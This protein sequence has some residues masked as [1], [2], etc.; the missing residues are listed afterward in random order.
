MSGRGTITAAILTLDEAVNLAALLPL[1]E[2]ADEI[3]VVDSGSRD[4]TVDVARRHGC[5][6]VERPFDS[7]AGQRNH[8][9][10]L[11]R[12]DWILSIDA[13]ERPVP[14]LAAEIRRHLARP[15]YEAFRLPICSTIFGRRFRRSGT[16]DDRPVRL[17]RKQSARWVGDVHEV[18]RVRGRVGRLQHGLEHRTMPSLE[19]FLAKMHRYTSLEARAR[20]AAG[21]GPKPSDAWIAPLREVFRRLIWKHGILD[22]PEGW[23]FC[24]LSGLSEWVLAREHRR[25][26]D[27]AVV[28]TGREDTSCAARPTHAAWPSRAWARL[29]ENS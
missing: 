20:V 21:R 12:G 27:S 3:V 9:I 2:W 23:A 14:G 25:L 29:A 17:F 16:Q 10:S 15:R 8:A 24:L 22:G 26:W 13:D 19:A 11:A 18:L 4:A 5:R 6:V 1:L 28:Q 7:F